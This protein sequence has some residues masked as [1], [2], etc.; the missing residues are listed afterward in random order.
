MSE[1]FAGF[2]SILSSFLTIGAAHKAPPTGAP[3]TRTRRSI[4]EPFIAPL[5][6]NNLRKEDY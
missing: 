4:L 5:S 1:G 6:P 3:I 2:S